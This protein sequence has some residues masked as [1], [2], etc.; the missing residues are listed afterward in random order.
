M[1]NIISRR[2]GTDIVA[3]AMY[4]KEITFVYSQISVLIADGDNKCL[5]T[6]DANA[7]SDTEVIVKL[8]HRDDNFLH[9]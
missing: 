1:F 3:D 8:P 4:A 2:R 6:Q 7:S 9:S 5:S